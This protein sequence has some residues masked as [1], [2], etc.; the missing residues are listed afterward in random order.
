LGFLKE[1]REG[2]SISNMKLKIE[3]KNIKKG[4]K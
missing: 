4:K 3:T 1:E 2:I